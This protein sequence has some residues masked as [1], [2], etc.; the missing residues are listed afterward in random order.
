MFAFMMKP[1]AS[2]LQTM[3][4]YVREAPRGSTFRKDQVDKCC[5]WSSIICMCADKEYK[6]ALDI[7]VY[8]L[9]Q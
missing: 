8:Q 5:L 2:F 7:L 6:G 9:M 3:E 4:E 1:P